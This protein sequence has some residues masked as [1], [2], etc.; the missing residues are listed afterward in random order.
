[1]PIDFKNSETKVNLMK[2][3]AGESQARNR[4]EMSAG[5]AKKQNLNVVEM[6]F[7]FKDYG[8]SVIVSTLSD[9]KITEIL[10]SE[11]LKELLDKINI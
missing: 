5:V 11:Y 3:F 4:Y 8:L 9:T 6:I 1:M 7:K 2:A 10:T